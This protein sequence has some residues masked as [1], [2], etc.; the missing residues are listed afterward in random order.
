MVPKNISTADRVIRLLIGFVLL[1][2]AIFQMSVIL[3]IIALFCFFEASMSWCVMYQLLG[4]NT[5]RL[6]K[7]K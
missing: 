4:I 6:K 3:L 7:K 2:L 5:C 1:G